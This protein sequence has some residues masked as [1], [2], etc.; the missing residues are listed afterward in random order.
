MNILFTSA[1]RR[2]YLVQYF[3]KTIGDSGTIHVANS[4]PY[5]TAMKYGDQTVITPLISDKKYIPFLLEYCLQ[6]Q[7][8]ILIPLFDMDLPV[9][10]KNKKRFEKIGVTVI[11]ASE[12]V[13]RICNDK[14]ESFKFLQWNGFRTP[15]TFLSIEEAKQ[16]IWKG[17]IRFPVILKPRWGAGSLSV[18]EAENE[19]EMELFYD[20]IKRKV[21]S[22]KVLD[23][24]LHNEDNCVIIQQKL[25]GQEYGLDIINDLHGNHQTTIVKIKHAMRSGETDFAETVDEPRLEYAGMRLGRTLGHIANLDVDAFILEGVPYILEMNGRFG[26]GYPF[27][28]IAGTNL[29]EAIVRWVKGERIKESLLK[30]KV[31]VLG[32]KE[33]LIQEET[34]QASIL[35]TNLGSGEK[36]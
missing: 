6:H 2:N 34:D 28:H 23:A 12:E 10:S 35:I 8:D 26:G 33:I 15:L 5:S 17:V 29:P 21:H 25:N 9:L 13:I 36:Q 18:Y 1:G 27:S 11:V 3:K 14:W 7:I 16:A 24:L 4:T 22:R 19:E 30:G 20:K 31:G 32:Y